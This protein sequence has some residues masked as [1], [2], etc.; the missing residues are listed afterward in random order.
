MRFKK[1][2][3]ELNNPDL[4]LLSDRGRQYTLLV[5]HL[6]RPIKHHLVSKTIPCLG[7]SFSQLGNQSPLG[8][9]P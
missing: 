3:I 7:N 8:H 1:A 6:H 9:I 4:Q 5:L 2:A